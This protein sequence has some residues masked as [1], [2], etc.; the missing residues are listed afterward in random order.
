MTW[1]LLTQGP[2]YGVFMIL[3]SEEANLYSVVKIRSCLI[4]FTEAC[5]H[6]TVQDWQKVL[7][8]DKIK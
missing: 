8:S 4:V 1:T 6:R 2:L 5:K 3:A 7:L